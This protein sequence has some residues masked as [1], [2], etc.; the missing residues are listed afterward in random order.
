MLL[1]C[2]QQSSTRPSQG[3]DRDQVLPAPVSTL[4]EDQLARVREVYSI[5]GEVS[6][7]TLH[8]W[9]KS[10][11]RNSN[12]EGQIRSWGA[13]AR[14]YQS[15]CSTHSSSAEGK[16]EVFDILLLR[17]QTP[18]GEAEALRWLQLKVLTEGEARAVMDSY[19]GD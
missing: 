3:L 11:E 16:K 8:E 14:A 9:I 12:P 15:Y 19:Q 5:L 4:S 2:T 13:I 17:S 7:I 18:G 1:S 6:G 10:T